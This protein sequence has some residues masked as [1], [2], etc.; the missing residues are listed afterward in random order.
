[1]RVDD[2]IELNRMASEKVAAA[3][4]GMVEGQKEIMR[5]SAAAMK[6]RLNANDASAV[7]HASLRPAMRT[8]KRNASRLPRR[9][10]RR[11]GKPRQ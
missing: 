5:L 7:V 2:V 8:V 11:F 4:L 10:R 1:M 6:G 3:A 9:R